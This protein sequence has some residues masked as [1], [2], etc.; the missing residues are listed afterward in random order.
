M[1]TS[2][3]GSNQLIVGGSD[4]TNLKN[5]LLQNLPSLSSFFINFCSKME[6]DLDITLSPDDLSNLPSYA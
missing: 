2:I 4:F 1:K 3:F 6:H 5:I